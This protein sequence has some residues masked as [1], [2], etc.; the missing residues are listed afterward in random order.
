MTDSEGE[1]G[2]FNVC[3]KSIY[4]NL[5]SAPTYLLARQER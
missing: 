2:W 5:Q 1:G 4:S 3:I